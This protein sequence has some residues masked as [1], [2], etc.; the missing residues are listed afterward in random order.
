MPEK[1][2]RIRETLLGRGW[3]GALDETA[4]LAIL[5]SGRPVSVG[6]GK[7]LFGPDDTSGGVFGVVLGGIVL[8]TAGADG[9]YMPGHIVRPG[10]WFGYGSVLVEQRRTL[11]A[12]A[13][14]ASEVLHL[15]LANVRRL[16][17]QGPEFARAFALLPAYGEAI[18]LAIVSDLL[19]ADSERRLASVL[20][21]I[22]NALAE[23][24]RQQPAEFPL[25]HELLGQ[26]A[27]ASRHTVA[28]FVKRMSQEGLISWQYGQVRIL[29]AN[30]LELLNNAGR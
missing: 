19:I 12:Q 5:E 28:R 2:N 20:L 7:V 22:T 18:L 11:L 3:L 15:P 17:E 27:N 13:N 21:R 25:T 16:R 23:T 29:D 8:S 30:R 1:M 9:L 14:E 24:D 26:L 4:A 10:G 6:R